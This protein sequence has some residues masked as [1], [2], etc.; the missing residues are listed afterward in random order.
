MNNKAYKE[1]P[2]CREEIKAVAHKCMHCHS[3][4]DGQDINHKADPGLQE[5]PVK[6]K[7]LKGRGRKKSFMWGPVSILSMLIILMTSGTLLNGGS[8]AETVPG[9]VTEEENGQG[10]APGPGSG[11][12]SEGVT[13]E[14][15]VSKYDP[16][17]Q[18]LEDQITAE[19]TALFNAATREYEEGSGNPLFLIQLINKY[20]REIQRVEDRADTAFYSLLDQMKDE[21]VSNNLP[22]DVIA[23]IEEDYQKDKQVKKRELTRFLTDRSNW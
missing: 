10:A 4:L 5:N 3:M 1:C 8:P 12:G 13:V 18:A 6:V 7:G 11:P 15:I 17:F 21:L 19:L 16:K 9:V 2:Y 22:V 20:N 14:D 23:E